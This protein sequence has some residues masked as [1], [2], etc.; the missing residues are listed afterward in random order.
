VTNLVVVCAEVVRRRDVPAE[1]LDVQDTRVYNMWFQ[2]R[3]STLVR[4]Y[5]GCRCEVR[6]AG[7]GVWGAGCRVWGAG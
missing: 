3:A 4:V 7:C 6:G 1:K 5:T 2:F